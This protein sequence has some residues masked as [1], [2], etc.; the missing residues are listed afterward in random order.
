MPALDLSVVVATRDR[1]DSLARCLASLRAQRVPPLEIVVV[2][3][4]S[5]DGTA[6]ALAGWPGVVPLRANGRGAAAAR[7]AG[8]AAARGTIVA[9]TDDD[10]EVPDD[11]TCRLLAP[12]SDDAVVAVGGPVAAAGDCGLPARLSQ[13]ITNG[14]VESLGTDGVPLLTSNN[15]AYRVRALRAAGVFDEDFRG[16]GAEERELQWRLRRHGRLVHDRSLV[17]T[18]RPGPG[19]GRFAAQQLA[20]GRG[21]R[22]Y[23]RKASGARP[24]SAAQYARAFRNG[25][26]AVI[27]RERPAYA[28]AFVLSQLMVA[29]GFVLGPAR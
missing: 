14:L 16:A 17:V 3:D 28:A 22:L 8:I 5:T 1:R 20:Y 9:V 13:A 10:C 25:W 23:Y 15:V 29:G 11:W 7:N 26:R 19:W 4:A 2:D 12:F 27:G 24:L 21:A 6:D 18:H